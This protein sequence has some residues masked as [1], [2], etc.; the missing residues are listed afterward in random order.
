MD[1]RSGV[2]LFGSR[3]ETITC[4]VLPLWPKCTR[5]FFIV[6]R[7]H[8]SPQ[9]HNFSTVFLAKLSTTTSVSP[10]DEAT[11]EVLATHMGENASVATSENSFYDVKSSPKARLSTPE[12][13]ALVLPVS[14]M[15][16]FQEHS[17]LLTDKLVYTGRQQPAPPP[18]RLHNRRMRNHYFTQPLLSSHNIR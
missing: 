12:R 8:C 4:N 10:V 7:C 16:A 15:Q 11:L 17:P 13:L 5:Q 3:R 6:S 14:R 9:K 2:I 1:G 18:P